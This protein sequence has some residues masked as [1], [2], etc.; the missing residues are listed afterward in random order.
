MLY[1]GL[2]GMG[3]AAGQIFITTRAVKTVKVAINGHVY[4]V[5]LMGGAIFFVNTIGDYEQLQEIRRDTWHIDKLT[6]L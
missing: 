5:E 1:K 6:G 4:S 3:I 2:H